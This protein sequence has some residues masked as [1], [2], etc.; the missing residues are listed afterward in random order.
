MWQCLDKVAAIAGGC[1]VAAGTGGIDAGTAVGAAMGGAGIITFFAERSEKH[2]PE[3]SAYLSKIQRAVVRALGNPPRWDGIDSST[4]EGWDW[5]L[6]RALP[7]CMLDRR[8]LASAIV[9]RN[10][11]P[12]AA[13]SS[14][15]R[16]LAIKEPIFAT[17]PAQDFARRVISTALTSAYEDRVYFES[18]APYLWAAIGRAIDQIRTTGEKIGADVKQVLI[19]Q[20]SQSEQLTELIELARRGGVFQQAAAQGISE[21]AVRKIVEQLGGYN[22]S[23]DD[24]LK[25]L[26]DWVEAAR[27]ALG[28]HNDEGEAFEAARAEAERRFKAGQSV[29]ASDSFMELLDREQAEAQRRQIA[30]IEAAIGFDVLSL[31]IDGVLSKTQMLAAASGARGAQEKGEFFFQRAAASCEIGDNQGDNLAL[32]IGIEIYKLALEELTEDRNPFNWAITQMNLANALSQLG[33]RESGA[34]RIEEAVIRG[35]LVVT[36]LTREL[37]PV[38]WAVAQVNLCNA[39]TCLG[40]RASGTAQLEEAIIAC[41]LALEELTRERDPLSWATTQINLAAT[42]NALG[43][44]EA[45]G[46]R[47]EESVAACRLALEVRTRE[48]EP[49]EWARAQINLAVPL[50]ALGRRANA[51]VL[52]E[53]A[54]AAYR[55]G[56]EELTRDRVPLDWAATQCNLGSVLTSLGE[57]ESGRARFEEAIV[58]CRLALEERTRDRV[59]LEWAQTQVNLAVALSALGRRAGATALLEE[60]A[61][62][63]R[64]ALEELTRERVPLDWATTQM[65][66]GS[67]L[68]SLVECEYGTARIEEAVAACRLALEERTRERVPLDWAVGQVNL[69]VALSAQANRDGQAA[70]YVEAVDACRMALQELTRERVPLDWATTQ[71]NLGGFLKSL[72]ELESGTARFEE[73]IFACR[74]ALEERTRERHPLQWAETQVNL[75][76]A[77]S[78]L[79]KREVQAALLNEA[80]VVCRLALEELTPMRLPLDWA[81]ACI[82]LVEFMAR[83]ADCIADSLLLDEAEAL[84]RQTQ[85]V[86]DELVD[87]MLSKHFDENFVLIAKIRSRLAAESDGADGQTVI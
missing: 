87:Y 13:T 82:N 38:E 39:L 44:R 9:D 32:L 29:L 47:F 15:V 68:T 71:N 33:W 55:L 24:L 48:R 57:R 8:A 40:K 65:N 18:L 60:A 43:E 2:G 35:R 69:A 31:N 64:L 50:S 23:K 36:Q 3:S 70:L 56:L 66:L 67:V 49:L 30:I 80:V 85:P 45:G 17:S 20:Q 86:A 28:R 5:S 46:E 52:L 41:R 51:T 27:G 84:L 12:E 72:G 76:C 6:S 1:I 21:N 37:F 26:E 81:K 62:A 19:E 77:L 58:A 7:E 34:A 42:L 83:L 63:Y 4:V 79:G 73:A 78:A 11:F 53:E 75:A 74:L 14:V 22:V 54:V 16:Q 10:G 61:G 59:P 25:W